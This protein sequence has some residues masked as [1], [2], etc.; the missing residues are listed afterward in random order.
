[1]QRFG[2]LFTDA[3]DVKN[4]LKI[5]ISDILGRF[6]SCLMEQLSSEVADTRDRVDRLTSAPS[7][8]FSLR[9]ATNVDA[10]TG[11]TRSETNVFS[12]L[13][14]GE[15]ELIVRHHDFHRVVVVIDDD[16]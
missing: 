8:L 15:R 5:A 2:F 14:D 10:P 12:L 4:I 1:M 11:K 13:A 6:E 3:F 9:L 7:F 16:F